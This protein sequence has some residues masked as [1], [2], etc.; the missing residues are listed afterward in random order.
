VNVTLPP[1]RVLTRD[2]Y[3][4]WVETQPRGRFERVDGEVVPM[5]A[6]RVAHNLVKQAVWLTLR[7]SLRASGLSG[8]VFGDGVTIEIGETH[9][10]EPDAVLRLG[11]P[12]DPDEVAAPD[13][14]VIVEVASPSTSAIDTGVKLADYFTLPTLRHYLIVA[15]KR[16]RV[17]HHRRTTADGPIETR[18]L[19]AG[20]LALDPPGLTLDIADF[21][22]S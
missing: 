9:D 8:Q 3:R 6:E 20:P 13:P 12:I 21:Y 18:I 7:E 15:A 2:E 16:Q 10:Y 14:V 5:A 17:V 22:R 4:A 11:P 19:T 1:R